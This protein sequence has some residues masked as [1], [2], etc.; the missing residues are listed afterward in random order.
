MD[1]VIRISVET[2]RV[3][4]LINA[5]PTKLQFVHTLNELHVD[6]VENLFINRKLHPVIDAI[7]TALT[8]FIMA[9]A[10]CSQAEVT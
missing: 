1:E 6:N 9:F 8:A 5:P 3:K 2:R 4:L 7:R 10:E